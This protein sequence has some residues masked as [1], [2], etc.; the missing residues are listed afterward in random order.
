VMF[1]VDFQV[2]DALGK[3]CS[4]LREIFADNDVFGMS[5]RANLR[6]KRVEVAVDDL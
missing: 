4:V 5:P 1:I 3:V 2:V 6:I